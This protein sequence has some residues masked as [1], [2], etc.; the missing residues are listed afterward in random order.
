MQ[1]DI[2]IYIDTTSHRNTMGNSNTKP[3]RVLPS[4]QW[5]EFCSD[6]LPSDLT[7]LVVAVT[8]CTSGTGKVFALEA[9]KRGA[10]LL[11]LN[12]PSE[13]SDAVLFEVKEVAPNADKIETVNCDLTS[14]KSVH[15]CCNKIVAMDTKLNVLCNNAGVM[16]LDDIATEDGY[17]IQMQTN[18]LSQFLLT[19]ELMPSLT[20]AA[21]E[22]G[23]A[24]IVNHSSI[25]RHWPRAWELKEENIG[26]NG[27][28]LGGNTSGIWGSNWFR[29]QQSK[30][31]NVIFTLALHDRLSE[32]GSKV[33]S[34][35]THPGVSDTELFTKSHL[36]KDKRGPS[37]FA[38]SQEDG[39]MGILYCAFFPKINS[40][41]FWGPKDSFC[42]KGVPKITIPGDTCTCISAKK[43]LWDMSQKATEGFTALSG[44]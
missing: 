15:E 26:R 6:A 3:T 39:A 40:G 8:G 41:E 2:Y 21:V 12:R 23:E 1:S 4:K 14:F 29:Y 36:N 30:L 37:M 11:L 16:K 33:K 27:G 22:D 17:D 42:T 20:R 25:A 32:S 18:H 9:A 44:S 43:L 38:Q 31:A 19:R 13:R 35:V 28:N 24:R 10:R 34:L 7:N 5:E